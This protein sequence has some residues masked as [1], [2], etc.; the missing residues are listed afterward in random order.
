LTPKDPLRNLD[1]QKEFL[2]LAAAPPLRRSFSVTKD[3]QVMAQERVGHSQ[4]EKNEQDLAILDS[5]AMETTK[6]EQ[7]LAI[8]DSQATETTKVEQDLVIL[9]SQV[10]ATTKAEQDLATTDFQAIQAEDPNLD[11][12]V[13]INLEEIAILAVRNFKLDLIKA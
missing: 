10:T 13:T 5:Q 11:L 9:D 4:V 8:L 6:V 12:M 7:D 3:S 1:H 2:H